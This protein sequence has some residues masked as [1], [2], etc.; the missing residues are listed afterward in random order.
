MF[1]HTDDTKV[2]YTNGYHVNV[3]SAS[4][5]RIGLD[6]TC[7]RIDYNNFFMATQPIIDE[8]GLNPPEFNLLQGIYTTNAHQIKQYRR[9]RPY[10]GWL[11][12]RDFHYLD[13]KLLNLSRDLRKFI[14]ARVKE[15][16]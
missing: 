12:N 1:S 4:T 5:A 16:G 11:A 10:A 9:M 3:A 15:A 6:E 7:H 13:Y 8:Q 14:G 2:T